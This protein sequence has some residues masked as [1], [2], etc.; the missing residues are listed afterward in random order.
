MPISIVH[1]FLDKVSPTH[2]GQ[3]RSFVESLLAKLGPLGA[4]TARATT[5]E[6]MKSR[7]G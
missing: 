2:A 6:L 1:K 4:K 3:A 7:H 5:I